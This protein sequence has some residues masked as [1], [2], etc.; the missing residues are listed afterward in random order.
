MKAYVRTNSTLLDVLASK[1][2]ITR[3]M[4]EAGKR[5][6]KDHKRVYGSNGARDSCVPPIGGEAFETITQAAMFTRAKDRMNRILNICG[7]GPYVL[8]RRI[9]AFEE[10]IGDDRYGPSRLY[11]ELRIGL[12]ACAKVYGVPD[13]EDDG[14]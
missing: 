7:P 13:Y 1:G 2:V 8:V 14:A 12:M 6:A 10:A 9:C 11:D 5:Y 4:S 3:Q